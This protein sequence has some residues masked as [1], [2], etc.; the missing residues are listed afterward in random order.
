M[1]RQR[2]S[3]P[4]AAEELGVHYMTAYRY[5][6]TGR[7]PANGSAARAADPP[8]GPQARA[9][10]WAWRS[11]PDPPAG[12][13]LPRLE[14]RLIAGDEAGT[15]TL[16]EAA[17]ASEATPEDLLLELIAPAFGPSGRGLGSEASSRSP[18]NTGRAPSPP[19]SSAGWV[20]AS[21]AE[22]SSGGW[23]SRPPPVSFTRCRRHRCQPAAL[24]GLRRG[25]ARCG[26][27]GRG[28]R[29]AILG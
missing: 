7:L 15:W 6:R 23:S 29:P 25:G 26:Y 19:G 18:T 12:A 3:L 4:E 22:A 28:A 14:A 20:R 27:P 11:V 24:E 8:C 16:L 1:A 9:A 2:L 5:V 13:I 21:P 10:I 17:L